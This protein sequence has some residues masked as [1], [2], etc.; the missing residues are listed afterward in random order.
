MTNHDDSDLT[1][2][3]CGTITIASLLITVWTVAAIL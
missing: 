3:V 1:D 2:I